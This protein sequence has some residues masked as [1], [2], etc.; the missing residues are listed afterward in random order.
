MEPSNCFLSLIFRTLG[1]RRWREMEEG[2]ASKSQMFLHI[3]EKRPAYLMM[4]KTSVAVHSSLCRY[5]VNCFSTSFDVAV[6]IAFW[7]AGWAKIGLFGKKKFFVFPLFVQYHA[8][9]YFFSVM[10]KLQIVIQLFAIYPFWC[11][12]C[13]SE[14]L[15]HCL[16]RRICQAVQSKFCL[17]GQNSF[18]F[19]SFFLEQHCRINSLFTL[20][21]N[22]D[23]RHSLLFLPCFWG[24]RPRRGS[25]R[26]H[27]DSRWPK[28]I[29]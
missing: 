27:P 13:F 7:S 29:C 20:I 14:T 21:S 4:L 12:T 26:D 25:S 28:Q 10:M 18:G 19:F 1:R 6:E 11:V 2:V 17:F 8:N 23:A 22:L 15:W 5:F 3:F 24:E 9:W 16:E